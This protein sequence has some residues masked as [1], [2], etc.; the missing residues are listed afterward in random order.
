MGTMYTVYSAQFALNRSC[1]FICSKN[2]KEEGKSDSRKKYTIQ[3]PV[4]SYCGRKSAPKSI[5]DYMNMARWNRDILNVSNGFEP[6]SKT[7]RKCCRVYIQRLTQLV[8]CKD[9]FYEKTLCVLAWFN[10]VRACNRVL[11]IFKHQRIMNVYQ[12][13]YY[14]K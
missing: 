14:W 6:V 12:N 10:A 13:E 4:L 7:V 3:P 1:R 9:D 8:A 11:Q 5:V 2:K